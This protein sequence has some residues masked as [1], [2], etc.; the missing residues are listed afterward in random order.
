[1]RASCGLLN[2]PARGYGCRSQP[3]CF[4]VG[5]VCVSSLLPQIFDLPLFYCAICPYSHPSVMAADLLQ[6]SPP[7]SRRSSSSF[8]SSST[9]TYTSS[10]DVSDLDFHLCFGDS[11]HPQLDV[12]PVSPTYSFPETPVTPLQPTFFTA[13]DIRTTLPIQFS[14]EYS[15]SASSSSSG[16]STSGSASYSYGSFESSSSSPSSSSPYSSASSPIYLSD[17]Y[18]EKIPLSPASPDLLSPGAKDLL[19]EFVLGGTLAVELVLRFIVPADAF[20]LSAAA[21]SQHRVSF[22]PISRARGTSHR[23]RLRIEHVIRFCARWQMLHLQQPPNEVSNQI[24]A[25]PLQQSIDGLASPS[26]LDIVPQLMR[27]EDISIAVEGSVS[28]INTTLTILSRSTGS[29]N[30]STMTSE[31]MAGAPM[32]MEQAPP[33]AAPSESAP[34]P[35]SGP[36]AYMDAP[37]AAAPMAAPPAAMAPEAAP[38]MAEAMDTVPAMEMA[39]AMTPEKRKGL[40]ALLRKNT[41]RKPSVDATGMAMMADSSDAASSMMSSTDGASS[42]ATS[43]TSEGEGAMLMASAAPMGVSLDRTQTG[44]SSASSNLLKRIGSKLSG[45]RS[46]HSH[47]N[48]QDENAARTAPSAITAALVKLF[49]RNGKNPQRA[50]DVAQMIS[51]MAATAAPEDV[52][53]LTEMMQAVMTQPEAMMAE[54]QQA[55]MMEAQAQPAPAMA[56]QEPS[57]APQ[58]PASEV[59]MAQAPAAPPMAMAEAAPPM[60]MMPQEPAAMMAPT[61][62]SVWDEPAQ[63]LRSLAPA[64]MAET[65]QPETMAPAAPMMMAALQPETMSADAQAAPTIPPMLSPSAALALVSGAVRPSSQATVQPMAQESMQPAMQET[66]HSA[67]PASMQP[68]MAMH[69]EMQPTMGESMQSTMAPEPQMDASPPMSIDV[70]ASMQSMSIE[71]ESAA[72]PSPL[73]PKIPDSPP[74][75]HAAPPDLWQPMKKQRKPAHHH[76]APAVVKTVR[77][78]PAPTTPPPPPPVMAQ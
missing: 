50:E 36:P 37:P 23:L 51:T 3:L 38:M 29:T 59:A 61:Q 35:A 43:M 17:D 77:A 8:A 1:M 40:R 32:A 7:L 9:P 68:S 26:H 72:P 5:L 52:P 66:M 69:S 41:K 33:P 12:A 76:H 49:R 62:P 45:S 39:D 31:T 57:M 21:P 67:M 56:A 78:P 53:M 18:D 11:A 30:M 28:S 70:N 24:I 13:L 2:R 16:F 58:A 75:V 54:V 14:S 25:S 73:T 10:Q 74:P 71:D 44:S 27:S 19:P 6:N 63:P 48:S 64:P 20:P 47:S 4:L 65:M 34:P 15:P 22:P 60:A 55:M 46:Q 42:M